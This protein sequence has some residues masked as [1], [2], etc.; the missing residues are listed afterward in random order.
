M[1]SRPMTV[2]ASLALGVAGLALPVT[3]ASA[4][5]M[6]GESTVGAECVSRAA[7]RPAGTRRRRTP[8][9]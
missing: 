8:T 6:A 1:P 2:L 4:Q 3:S 5:P 7:R 9:S